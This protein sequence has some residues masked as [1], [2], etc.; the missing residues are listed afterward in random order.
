LKQLISEPKSKTVSREAKQQQ[1][2][3]QVTELT[4]RI[5]NLQKTQLH[6]SNRLER[7]IYTLQNEV[8][9]KKESMT[10]EERYDAVLL[11]VAELKQVRD[12]LAGDLPYEAKGKKKDHAPIPSHPASHSSQSPHSPSMPRDI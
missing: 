8:V 6:M 5:K 11:A 12:V 10:A 2:Q 7:I 4:A 3:Q 9:D 1:H